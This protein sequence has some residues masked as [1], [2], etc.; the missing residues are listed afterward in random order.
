M[1]TDGKAATREFLPFVVRIFS[2]VIYAQG[3]SS[4]GRAFASKAKGC[5]F[6]SRRPCS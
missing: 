3:R 6:D 4:I 5:E 1:T 2:F